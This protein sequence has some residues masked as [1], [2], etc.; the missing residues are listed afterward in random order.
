MCGSRVFASLRRKTQR[1]LY[2]D[3]LPSNDGVAGEV[4]PAMEFVERDA[5]TVGD[6][7]ERV[8]ATSLVELSVCGR[9]DRCEGND[10]AIEIGD[11]SV[12]LEIVCSRDLIHGEVIV[13]RERG[14]RVFWLDAVVTPLGA[15]VL[16]NCCDALGVQRRHSFGEVEIK[17]LSEC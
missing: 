6:G 14:E 16:R 3:F 1:S 13:L 15:L 4:I 8:S 17:R 7:D 10:D 11:C 9:H 2:A 12:A 5:E